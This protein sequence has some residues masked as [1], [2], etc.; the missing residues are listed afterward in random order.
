MRRLLLALLAVLFT[1]T[2]DAYNKE[3]VLRFFNNWTP[4]AVKK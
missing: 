1:V 2:I 3:K 4:S